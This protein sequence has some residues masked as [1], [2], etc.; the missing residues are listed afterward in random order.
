MAV[1]RIGCPVCGNALSL[2]V[3]RWRGVGRKRSKRRGPSRSE[4]R[5]TRESERGVV[6]PSGGGGL[7]A[8][9]PPREFPAA[10]PRVKG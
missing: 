5:A 6:A 3:R 1:V 2:V 10:E 8:A 9:G 7:K 4:K